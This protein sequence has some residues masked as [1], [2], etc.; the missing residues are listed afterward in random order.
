MVEGSIA[1][2]S[3]VG[4]VKSPKRTTGSW[5]NIH[6]RLKLLFQQQTANPLDRQTSLRYSSLHDVIQAE[7]DPDAVFLK[8]S[9]SSGESIN[10]KAEGTIELKI[11][12]TLLRYR[13]LK[14]PFM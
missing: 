3:N 13:I 2:N 12:F 1:N 14:K 6:H 7:V 5:A 9:E 10:C 4:V 11:Y 8:T